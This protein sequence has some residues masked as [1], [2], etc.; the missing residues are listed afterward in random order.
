MDDIFPALDR[1][2]AKLELLRQVEAEH[3]FG[4]HVGGPTPIPPLPQMPGLAEVYAL[5]GR[6]YGDN[7][8]FDPPK[9]LL[10]GVAWADR[11]DDPGCPM[12]TPLIIGSELATIPKKLRADI[13]RSGPIRL[14]TQDRDVYWMDPDAY[15]FL[16][17]HPDE[18]AEFTVLAPDV[19]TFFDEV[20]LGPGYPAM[21]DTVCGAGAAEQRLR[22]GRHR[23]AYEDNWRRLLNTAGL[24]E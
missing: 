8:R 15:L 23:G 9:E 19:V 24:A 18:E 22:R 3:G 11:Y 21:V 10:D 2:R 4:V 17:E 1:I 20:V 16:Y 13:P 7:F 6:L 12:G 5:F 14:D